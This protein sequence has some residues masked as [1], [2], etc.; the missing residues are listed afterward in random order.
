MIPILTVGLETCDLTGGVL[1]VMSDVCSVWFTFTEM[2]L[3]KRDI[4]RISS[5]VSM[6]QPTGL[7]ANMQISY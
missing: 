7:Y 5:I 3:L 1:T 6:V 2:T 4:Y